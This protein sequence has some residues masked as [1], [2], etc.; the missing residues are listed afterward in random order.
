MT[1]KGQ[2]A[3]NRFKKFYPNEKLRLIKKKEYEEI[4]KKFSERIPT[5]ED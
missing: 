1:K 3:I 5:W 2:T 4:K